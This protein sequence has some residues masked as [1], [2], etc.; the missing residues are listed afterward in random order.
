MFTY[1][2][3]LLLVGFGC[4][5]LQFAWRLSI[6]LHLIYSLL[7]GRFFLVF[8]RECSGDFVSFGSYPAM[9]FVL[10]LSFLLQAPLFNDLDRQAKF[11]VCLFQLIIQPL[12]F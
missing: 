8:V 6:L 2:L 5:G 11:K 7:F 1:C 4:L 9:S 3:L 12:G 10:G